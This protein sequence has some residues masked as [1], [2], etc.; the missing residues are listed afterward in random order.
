[1]VLYIVGGEEI[2]FLV[3]C[4]LVPVQEDEFLGHKFGAVMALSIRAFPAASLQTPFDVDLGA[5]VEAF[6]A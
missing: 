5:F 2:D 3:R 4:A 6:F 1:L